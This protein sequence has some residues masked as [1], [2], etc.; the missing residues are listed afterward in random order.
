MIKRSEYNSLFWVYS[1]EAERMAVNHDVGGSIP[2]I[3]VTNGASSS[4]QDTGL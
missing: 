3:P 4:G 1:S 2:S